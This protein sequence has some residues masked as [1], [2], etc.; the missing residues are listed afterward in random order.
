MAPAPPPRGELRAKLGSENETVMPLVICILGRMRNSG[1]CCSSTLSTDT[2]FEPPDNTHRHLEVLAAVPC[3]FRR[4]RDS[5]WSNFWDA[6]KYEH[7]RIYDCLM[8]TTWRLSLVGLQFADCH[9]R[10]LSVNCIQQNLEIL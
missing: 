2:F 6:Y 7:I 4:D 8:V 1:V 9:G 10:Q 5:C 3:Y